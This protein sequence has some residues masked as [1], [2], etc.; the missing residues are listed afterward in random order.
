MLLAD[1][2][3][4][5]N[6]LDIRGDIGIDIKGIAYDSRK[7]KKGFVFVCIDGMTTEC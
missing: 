1:L 5:I 7:A 4:D 6:V 2:I 3:K